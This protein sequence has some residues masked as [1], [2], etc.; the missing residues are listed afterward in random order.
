LAELKKTLELDP[1]N[2]SIGGNIAQTYNFLRRWK[3]AEANASHTLTIDPHE[4][5]SMGMLLISYLN[6]DGNARDA[7]RALASYPSDD[8]LIPNGGTYVMVIGRRA[9]THILNHDYS[10][11]LKGWENDTR[12]GITEGQRLAAKTTIRVLAGDL[13][14]AQTDAE[15]ARLFFEARLREHPNEFRSMRALSWIYLAVD[16]K[17]DA[18][19]IAQQAFAL[20]PPEKDWGLGPAN[21]TAL[22]EM[23]ARTGATKDAISNLRRLVSIPA[24]EAVSI[25]RL[26]IDPVWDPI[27]KDPG[28]QQ[29]LTVKEHVGP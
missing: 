6:R 13:G 23:Q 2:A 26:K 28:F 16:R 22:A 11:A 19:K 20:L 7:L 1:R 10:A 3:D 25:A 5:T 24:G 17:E 14:D 18:L 4:A 21:L 27:R 29:L 12:T 9:E 8:L 15:K